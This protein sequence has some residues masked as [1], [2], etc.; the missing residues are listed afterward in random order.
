MSQPIA[1]PLRSQLEN[2]VKS[3]RDV[4]EKAALAALRQLAIESCPRGYRGVFWSQVN[5]KDWTESAFLAS[6]IGGLGLGVAPKRTLN[7]EGELQAWLSEVEALIRQKLN[8][9]PVSL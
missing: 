8:S 6:K 1:K 5:A 7:D 3:A 9:G 2:T 4:A